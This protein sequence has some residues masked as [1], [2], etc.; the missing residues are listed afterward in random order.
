MAVG[1]TSKTIEDV[2][3]IVA[4][5]INMD[6]ALFIAEDIAAIASEVR[7]LLHGETLNAEKAAF[8]KKKLH[9][10]KADTAFM[11]TYVKGLSSLILEKS[12]R[13][14]EIMEVAISRLENSMGK[15]VQSFNGYHKAMSMSSNIR[16]SLSPSV[17]AVKI[18]EN[19]SKGETNSE[20]FHS[21][22]I[23]RKI[24]QISSLTTLSD[25]LDKY[26]SEI[27]WGGYIV[28]ILHREGINPITFAVKMSPEERM[29]IVNE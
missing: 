24:S 1:I 19:I 23:R 27:M 5:D 16:T 14:S 22:L 17:K 2:R 15:D 13:V 21:E 25:S 26:I 12:S 28:D 3:Y 10:S 4:L 7:K 20:S 9:M 8:F 18:Y 29:A 11:E 6:A